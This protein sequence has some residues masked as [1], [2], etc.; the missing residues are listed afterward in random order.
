MK[1]IKNVKTG[2]IIR[3]DDRQAIQMVGNAWQYVPKSEWKAIRQPEPVKEVI[4]AEIKGEQTKS[5]KA[6]RRSK[7]KATQRPQEPSDKI[8]K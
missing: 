1:C 6:R 3:V 8:L 5:D 2:N 7:I 4:E